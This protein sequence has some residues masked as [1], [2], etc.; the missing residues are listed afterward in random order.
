MKYYKS[1]FNEVY[2]KVIQ[3]QLTE[4]QFRM[5]TRGYQ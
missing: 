4:L 5:Q 2:N 3:V 1:T